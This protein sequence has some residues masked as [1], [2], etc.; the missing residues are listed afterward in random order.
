MGHPSQRKARG[1][2]Q[3]GQLDN[4]VFLDQLDE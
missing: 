4:E 2:L 1:V 3:G